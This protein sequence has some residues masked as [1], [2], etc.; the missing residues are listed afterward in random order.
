MVGAL[1]NIFTIVKAHVAHP[2]HV[3]RESRFPVP[4]YIPCDDGKSQ[5]RFLYAKLNP[6]VTHNNMEAA[7][8][9]LVFTDDVSL[10]VGR[11]T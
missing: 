4:R 3:T 11:T 10:K 9:K 7:S 2:P 5:A 6:S 1:R 8:H